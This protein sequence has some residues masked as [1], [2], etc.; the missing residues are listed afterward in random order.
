ML[1]LKTWYADKVMKFSF[2]IYVDALRPPVFCCIFA[3]DEKTEEGKE[4]KV[5]KKQQGDTS[6]EKL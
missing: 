6:R 4:E 5:A 1:G 3:W 2:Q